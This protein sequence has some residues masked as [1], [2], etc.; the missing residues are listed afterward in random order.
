MAHVRTQIREA[1]KVALDGSVTGIAAGRA[2]LGR[3]Y[4][5]DIGGGAAL[6]VHATGSRAE[7][8]DV[9]DTARTIEIAVVLMLSGSIDFEDR[10]DAMAVDVEQIL[11]ADP[12]LQAICHDWWLV[13]DELELASEGETRVAR[14]SMNF[15]AFAITPRGNPETLA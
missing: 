3:H 4:P 11:E 7:P 5:I 1:V 10:L 14:L 13:D 15:A 6:A 8:G 12:A 2:Y 9:E